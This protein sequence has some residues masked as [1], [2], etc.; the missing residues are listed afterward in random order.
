MPDLLQSSDLALRLLQARGQNRTDL[1]SARGP[2]MGGLDEIGAAF[3]HCLCFFRV[4]MQMSHCR[5]KRRRF[6]CDHQAAFTLADEIGLA[7]QVG[8][9][10]WQPTSKKLVELER[11]NSGRCATQRINSGN[12][13]S[14]RA[15]DQFGNLLVWAIA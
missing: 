13:T 4:T 6:G 15:R 10:G 14:N 5:R 3:S 1:R 7:G 2:R 8:D 9:D 12:E 11:Q